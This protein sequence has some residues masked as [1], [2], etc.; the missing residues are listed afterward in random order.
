MIDEDLIDISFGKKRADVLIK[1][2]SL[3]NVLT[4]EIYTSDVAVGKG[5]IVATGDLSKLEANTTINATG[6]YIVPGLIDSHIHVEVTKL[7]VTRFAELVLPHGTTS[8]VT[9][10][11]QIAGVCGLDGMRSFLD[12]AARTNLK[13]FTG[14]AVKLPYTTPPSTVGH[15][16]SPKEHEIAQRWPEVVGTWETTSDLVLGRDPEAYEAVDMAYKNRLLVHGHCPLLRGQ[17]LA[18]YLTVGIRSDHES[19]T[20]EEA[21]EKARNGLYVLIRETPVAPNMDEVIKIITEDKINTRRVSMCIDDIN[22]QTLVNEGHLDNLVRK[23]IEHG[24]G[25]IDA[26]QMVTINPAEAYRLDHIIGSITP[27]KLADILLVD[28][29]R[30]FKVEKVI[31]SGQLVAENGRMLREYASP[32]RPEWLLKTVK[33][34]HVEARD[35]AITSPYDAEQVRVISMFVDENK[36]FYRHKRE[37]ILKVRDGIVQANP[38]A[39]VLYVSTVERY[40]GRGE[41]ATAFISGF[42]MV[43]G[44]VATSLSPD[45]NNIVCIG[46]NLRDMASAV[47]RISEIQG[48]QVVVKEGKIIAELQLPI[49]GIVTDEPATEVKKK[50]EELD[51]AIRSLGA[52]MRLPFMAM[53]FLPITAIPEYAITNK[54]LVECASQKYVNPVIAPARYALR[55]CG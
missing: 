13:L 9:G 26:I 20:R 12:E 28:D 1:N 48:G 38:D 10:L 49:G 40:T 7:S 23:A 4:G 43:Q 22:V 42:G 30:K 5:K 50:E 45:D 21:L 47:N 27:G 34:P 11:D 44:A 54:G 19:I 29:L 16:L 8:V 41:R 51:S 17:A 31:S 35:L 55:I 2:G 36:N 46:A 15:E 24:V 6:K 14:I 33:V 18:A 32:T 25:P 37:V 39:D 3:V 53:I 52:T